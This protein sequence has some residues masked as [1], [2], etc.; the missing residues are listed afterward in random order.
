MLLH[1]C[2]NVVKDRLIDQAD[3]REPFMVRPTFKRELPAC[4]LLTHCGRVTH[5]CNTLLTGD[6]DS[7]LYITTVQDG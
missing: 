5:I 7:R 4:I 2:V 1:V 3:K 6:A